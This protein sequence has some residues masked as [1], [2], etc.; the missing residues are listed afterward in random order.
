MN[1]EQ[2]LVGKSKKTIDFRD[3]LSS[4]SLLKVTQAFN[5]M[6]PSEILEIRGVDREVRQDLFKVLPHGGYELIEGED[7]SEA[8][9]MNSIRLR[10]SG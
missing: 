3:S 2:N 9:G 1:K 4:I 8:D 5:T 6:N 7:A 10:K